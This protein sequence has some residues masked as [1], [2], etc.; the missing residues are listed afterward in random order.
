MR[1]GLI[2]SLA[3]VTLMISTASA[4]AAVAGRQCGGFA[5]LRCPKGQ[6]CQHTPGTC[7]FADA[8]GTCTRAPLFCTKIF[9]PVCGCDG[10]TYPNDCVR[11]AARVSLS[12]AGRCTW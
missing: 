12:H 11:Q 9:L 5:G 10:K 3:A 7:F 4:G 1:K 8:F 2:V 6:F